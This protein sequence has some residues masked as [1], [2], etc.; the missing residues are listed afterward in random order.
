MEET[1]TFIISRD[2]EERR[3]LEGQSDDFKVLQYFML[4][5][6][7]SM[8]HCLKTGWKVLE[9]NEQTKEESFWKPYY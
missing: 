1:F 4:A 2:G 3:R 9:I 8:N 5:Q 7:Y 6:G